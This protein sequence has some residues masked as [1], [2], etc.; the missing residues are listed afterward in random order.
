M[1]VE[2][3][4]I[5]RKRESHLWERHPQD[6][7]VEPGWVSER[8]FQLEPFL[9][10]I[11]DPACGRGTIMHSARLAGY[12]AHG[13]DL[14][15]RFKGCP[16]R[17]WLVP[18]RLKDKNIVC[19]PPYSLCDDGKGNYP[20]VEACLERSRKVALILPLKWLVGDRRSRW[21]EQ[22]PLLRVYYITPRPSMPPG[23]VIDAGLPPGGGREDFIVLVWVR[24][25]PPHRSTN[26][27]LRKDP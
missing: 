12:K 3:L 20:F 15:A 13:T 1:A 18:S 25:H 17:D 23:P 14:V 7:Y 24:D 26:H 6:Y 2:W 4:P 11:Y 19:N 16:T 8:L 10:D 21:L 27:W 22:S 5:K 9:G